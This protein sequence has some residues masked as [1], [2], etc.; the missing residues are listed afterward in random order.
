[1]NG[2]C[3]RR[4]TKA[5]LFLVGSILC[6]VSFEKSLAF[7]KETTVMVSD[8][9]T[10]IIPDL[11]NTGPEEPEGG[12]TVIT[13]S[14]L[15][16]LINGEESILDGASTNNRFVLNLKY[17]HSYLNGEIVIENADLSDYTFTVYSVDAL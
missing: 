16:C 1:M 11:Y 5:M 15:P 7:A 9:D 12:F 2:N 6:F 8:N 4:M 17:K 10:K 3:V 14:K 13:D